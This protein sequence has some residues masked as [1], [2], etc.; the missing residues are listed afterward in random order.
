MNE[1]QTPV[2]FSFIIFIILWGY[3][4]YLCMSI[5][6]FMEV[7][8]N[9]IM[10]DRLSDLQRFSNTLTLLCQ[11]FCCQTSFCEKW[12]GEEV[13]GLSSSLCMFDLEIAQ[14]LSL[15]DLP[16]DMNVIN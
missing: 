7:D 3:A 13:Y 10:G 12:M 15:Y 2:V 14:L 9:K 5:V 4:V 11:G 8:S 6:M 1:I 16:H